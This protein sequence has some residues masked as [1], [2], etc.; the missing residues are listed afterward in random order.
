MTLISSHSRMQA[1]HDKET[2]YGL[3][4]RLDAHHHTLL[5]PS[6]TMFWPVM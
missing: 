1:E 6:M 4:A 2:L 5:P 3:T